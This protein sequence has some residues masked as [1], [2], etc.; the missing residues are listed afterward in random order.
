MLPGV[1]HSFMFLKEMEHQARQNIYTLN[2]SPVFNQ[3][4]SECNSFMDRCRGS[5]KSTL[6]R[7]KHQIQKG[8]DPEQVIKDTYDKARDYLDI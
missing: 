3:T 2:F 4:I 5:I 6:K 8:A 1:E 7:V